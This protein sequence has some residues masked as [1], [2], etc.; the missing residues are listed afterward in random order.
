M[1]FPWTVHSH[2]IPAS[3]PRSF[4]RGVR[5]LQIS[6]LKLHV[7][8]YRPH[9]SCSNKTRSPASPGAT[10][11]FAHGVGSTKESYEPFLADLLIHPSTPTINAIWAA[12]AAN[13][14]QSYRLNES[15]LGDEPHWFDGAHDIM[16][17]INHF[18]SSI[19]QPLI[20][21]GQS[22]GCVHLL[23]PAAWHPRI[24][25]GLVLMEPVLETGYYHFEEAK[26]R[27][28]PERRLARNGNVG[29]S[30]ALM[31]DSWP[32]RE[33][34][35]RHTRKLKYYAQFDPRVLE[36][37]LRY[38]LRDLPDGSVTLATPR[39]Q[40]AQ[41][42]MRADPPMKGYPVSEDHATKD[43]E[44]VVAQGFYRGEPAR[45][46]EYLPGVHCKAL[47]VWSADESFISTE[48]YR[49]RVIGLTGTGRGGGG[50]MAAGQVREVFVEADGHSLP[51]TAPG[52]TAGAIAGWFGEEMGARWEA[53]DEKW[54]GE[55]TIDPMT[56]PR[57]WTDRV[58]KL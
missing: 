24:F 32:S 30:V 43:R 25:Q 23:L 2:I 27:G 14:G 41:L 17:L 20:G 5:D 18:Q 1:S 10:I 35:E 36:R 7:N 8:E 56:V 11:I 39:Y 29:F 46:K 34:A 49:R 12:D 26:A 16:Q 37:T 22:W 44:S 31:R 3:Y 47:Y 55:A 4:R 51:F 53:E 19:T 57:E 15:E 52:N 42:F 40:Q 45:I 21:I 13:H 48:S 33:E 54:K 58:L 9:P 6:R 28:V 50:G 38:E